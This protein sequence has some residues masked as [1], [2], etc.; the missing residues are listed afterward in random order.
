MTLPIKNIEGC[1]C[2]DP[3]CTVPRGF[4]HCGCGG[5]TRISHRNH[6]GGAALK[7]HPVRYIPNHASLHRVPFEEAVPFRIADKIDDCYCRLIPLSRGMFAIV[8]ASDYEWLMRWP[9]CAQNDKRG[10]VYARRLEYVGS[11]RYRVIWMHKLIAG[12]T[13]RRVDHKSDV[14]L[15]NRRKNLRPANRFQNN[16]NQKT[17]SDSRVGL[18]GVGFAKHMKTRP[19]RAK[20]TVEGKAIHLGYFRTPEEAHAA[21]CAAAKHYFGEFARVA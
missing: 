5:K 12:I 7:G 1:I 19:W 16:Q 8:N 10:H 4:C 18:K 2:G 9:W 11:G 15:D 17:R 13:G 14:S 3:I 21:Y 20:I 6:H